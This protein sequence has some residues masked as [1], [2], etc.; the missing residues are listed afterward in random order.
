MEYADG[1]GG[2]TAIS[3]R[4]GPDGALVFSSS[5]ASIAQVCRLRLRRGCPAPTRRPS[6]RPFFPSHLPQQDRPAARISTSRLSDLVSITAEHRALLYSVRSAARLYA[7][8]RL[9]GLL[10]IDQRQGALRLGIGPILPAGEAVLGGP[11]DRQLRRPI[12]IDPTVNRVLTTARLHSL[13]EL[14]LIGWS[15]LRGEL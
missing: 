11:A 7:H 3:S 2:L 15:E 13:D 14:G 9:A 4:P 10:L 5:S 6:L 12:G 8:D 1:G